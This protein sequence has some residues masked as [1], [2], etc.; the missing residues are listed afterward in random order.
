[1]AYFGRRAGWASVP[2]VG[3]DQLSATPDQGPMVIEEDSSLTVV[4]P[5]WQASLDE[6]SNIVLEPA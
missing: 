3:R 5:G 6:W 2:V 1:M 4:N